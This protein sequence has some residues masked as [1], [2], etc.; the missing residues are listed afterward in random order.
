MAIELP[1]LNAIRFFESAARHLS[2][3]KAGEELFVTQGAVS[4]QIKLLEEQL[5]CRLFA[6]KGP[7]LK[8]TANGEKFQSSV[9]D[10]LAIIKQGTASLRRASAPTLTVSVLPSFASNW[11]VSRL[12]GLEKKHPWLSTRLAASY[13]NTDFSV[14]T[15]I[16]AGIRLGRGSWPGLHSEQLTKDRMFPVCSPKISGEI[17]S[18]ADLSNYIILTDALPYNEW[19]HWFEAAGLKDLS[20]ES[21]LYDDTGLQLKGAIEG[22]GVALAREE[23]VQD[24]LRSGVLVKL[25]DIDFIS[26]IHYYFVCP[27][28]E[29]NEKKIK[30]FRE[31]LQTV[32]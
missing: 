3:T 15:D 26:D 19:I 6:R 14:E 25:F 17:E 9:V 2:F 22:Q 32:K 18:V 13:A 28:R 5:D 11:L 30:V 4:R 29:I 1:S 27:E 16:D 7:Y 23:L 10:A 12:G 20:Y 31:W 24:Y 8:L 21:K